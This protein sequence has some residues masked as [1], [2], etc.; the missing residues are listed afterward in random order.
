M[1]SDEKSSKDESAGVASTS[2]AKY[3]DKE[4]ELAQLREFI[5]DELHRFNE[6]KLNK[7]NGLDLIAE[8]SKDNGRTY[9]HEYDMAI[10]RITEELSSIY[11]DLNGD[12]DWSKILEK[13]STGIPLNCIYG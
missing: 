3:A 6:S 11:L 2:A 8:T 12:I 7:L 4:I 13:N 5:H 10:M 1:V 9:K